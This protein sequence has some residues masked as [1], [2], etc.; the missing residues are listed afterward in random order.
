M[1]KAW[2]ALLMTATGCTTMAGNATRPVSTT[3]SVTPTGAVTMAELPTTPM[4]SASAPSDAARRPSATIAMLFASWC[5][6]CHAELA[7][8]NQLRLAHPE[9]RIVGLSYAPFEEFNDHGDATRLREFVTAEAP[10]LNV[11]AMS[12]TLYERL[13]QPAKIPSLWLFASD[14]TLVQT[15]NRAVRRAPGLDELRA[16]INGIAQP[17]KK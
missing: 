16:A 4:I 9:V 5:G 17:A 3:P 7:V 15:Y 13:Q 2:L 8:L 12:Q 6:P 11:Y 14:G 10:W 1:F